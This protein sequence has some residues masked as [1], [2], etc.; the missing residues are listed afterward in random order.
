MERVREVINALLSNR[1]SGD[2]CN[3]EWEGIHA[4]ILAAMPPGMDEICVALRELNVGLRN[5]PYSITLY[6]DGS[7]RVRNGKAGI[8]PTSEVG[9]F[10]RTCEHT[11]PLLAIRALIPK[12]EPTPEEDLERLQQFV[13]CWGEIGTR[14]TFARLRKRLEQ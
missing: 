10:G 2:L 9:Y 6:S 8:D 14:T 12:P 1:P 4:A 13:N 11:K 7:G 3:F 5:S